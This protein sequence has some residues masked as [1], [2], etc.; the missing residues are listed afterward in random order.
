LKTFGLFPAFVVALSLL[1]GVRASEKLFGENIIDVKLTLPKGDTYMRGASDP[2]SNLDVEITLTNKTAKE[3]LNKETLTVPVV[4]RFTPDEYDDLIG[5]GKEAHD[6][7]VEKKK[8]TKEVQQYPVNK[9]SLGYAYIEPKLGP[10]DDIEFII[11]KLPEEGQP[12]PEKPVLIPR[13]NRPDHLSSVDQAAI[14]YLPAGTSSPAYSLPVGKYYLIRDPGKYT[15]KAILRTIG[16]SDKPLKY[17][18][19]NEETFRVMPFKVIDKKIAE[20]QENWELYERGVPSFDYLLYQVKTGGLFDDIYYV[21]RISVRKMNK[22]EWTRLCSVKDG[23]QAQ[24]AQTGPNKVVVLA[25]HAKGD[26][27]TYEIDFSTIP[28]KVT[29]TVLELKAGNIP[30]LGADG[31]VTE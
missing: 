29:A 26:A 9:D 19:S 10:H 21:Q 3:N 15:I 2:V 1:G 18:E 4:S 27:G 17:A 31:K 6:A 11:T 14:K 23:T 24:V 8:T 16:D 12:A 28:P 5:R 22:W 25:A 7:A 20:V 13:D 30:K